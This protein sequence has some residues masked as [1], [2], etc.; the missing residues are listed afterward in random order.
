LHIHRNSL[1][2]RLD[3]IGL[4]TGRSARDPRHGL[5]LYLAAPADQLDQRAAQA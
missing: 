3:K 5:T 2:Y 4:R 1:I